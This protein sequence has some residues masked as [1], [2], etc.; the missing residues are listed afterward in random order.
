MSAFEV[1][2]APASEDDRRMLRR[3]FES[4]R[5]SA[6]EVEKQVTA[7]LGYARALGYDLSRRW[8]CRLNGRTRGACT[9]VE[10]GG[11][12]ALLLAPA[13]DVDWLHPDA[14]RFL[15]QHVAGH[16]SRRGIRLLQ[17]LIEP[18]DDASRSLLRRAGFLEIAVLRYLE[19]RLDPAPLGAAPRPPA[20]LEPSVV[21]WI[22][23]DREAHRLFAELIQ[24]TYAESLDC[25]GLCGLREMEDVIAGHRS[26]GR[27]MPDQWRLLLLE[28]RPI[29]CI[30]FGEH[31]IRPS[32]ELTYM[33]V[34]P[35]YRRRSI[36]TYV[37]DSGLYWARAAG[38][39]AVS[40]AVDA[41]NAPALRLYE[42]AGFAPTEERRALVLPLRVRFDNS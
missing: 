25:P 15:L 3:C 11:R 42:R 4:P 40:L 6:V 34:H 19:A 29:A 27:F 37:L 39:R 5:R 36:G 31:P 1:I 12:T 7:F 16:E 8:L 9:S 28:D 30:L 23:Y 21:R 13:I 26:A 20:S 18:H 14:Q 24:A 2:Q 10:S 33:G 22:S 35:E 32:M 17:A 41:S 38:K